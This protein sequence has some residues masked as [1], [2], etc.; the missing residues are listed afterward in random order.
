LHKKNPLKKFFYK[1]SFF[2]VPLFLLFLP[3]KRKKIFFN[4]SSPVFGRFYRFLTKFLF[5]SIEK[6]SQKKLKFHL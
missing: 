2:G 4:P 6:K 5:H 1:I 3:E